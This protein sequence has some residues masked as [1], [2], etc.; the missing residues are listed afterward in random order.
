MK[1]CSSE[2]HQFE[3]TDPVGGKKFSKRIR[4]AAGLLEI[5]MKNLFTSPYR[6]FKIKYGSLIGQKIHENS[7][8]NS[9]ITWLLL[10]LIMILNY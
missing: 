10:I 7:V 4:L 5:F 9:F 6:H 8:I 3:L 2:M 1:K